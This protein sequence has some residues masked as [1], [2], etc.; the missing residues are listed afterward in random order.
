MALTPRAVL[1]C[2][3]AALA[4]AALALVVFLRPSLTASSPGSP[5]TSAPSPITTSPS[6]SFSVAPTRVPRVLTGRPLATAW[7]TGYLT[8]S[9]R[10]D[11]RWGAAIADITDPDLLAT[12]ESQGPDSVGLYR[13]TSWRV[14]AVDPYTAAIDLPVDTPTRQILAYTATVTDDR[15]HRETKPFLLY[16]HLGADRRWTVTMIDQPYTSEG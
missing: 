2:V 3:A 6:A 7:L 1:I 13:L 14:T 8:R 5:A 12:L 16:S 10:D 11:P 9:S 4:A 15:G